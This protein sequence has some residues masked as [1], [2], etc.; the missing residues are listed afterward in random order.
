MDSRE[1]I[2]T[3]AMDMLVYRAILELTESDAEIKAAASEVS[4]LGEDIAADPALDEQS[5][6]ALERYLNRLNDMVSSHYRHLYIQ[7]AKDCV[8]LLRKLD[9]IK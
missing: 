1:E 8:E 7:G 2:L 6:A 4:N 5:R 9:V 3:D